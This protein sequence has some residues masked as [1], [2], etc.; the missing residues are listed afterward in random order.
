MWEAH[1]NASFHATTDDFSLFR[2]GSR[3]QHSARW[4]ARSK[5]PNVTTSLEAPPAAERTTT[6]ARFP[7][8]VTRC[9]QGRWRNP[10]NN[11]PRKRPVRRLPRRAASRNPTVTGRVPWLCARFAGTKSRPIS[12]FARYAR[13]RAR[14]T[15]P[16][17]ALPRL[18]TDVTFR[19]VFARA[20][21]LPEAGAR[22]RARVHPRHSLPVDGHFGPAGGHRVLP[23][24]FVRRHKPL[25]HPRQARDDYAEGH[26]SCA[27]N[28]RRENGRRASARSLIIYASL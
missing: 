15:P 9:S 19:R 13:E 5:P 28:T 2:D 20:G 18:F 27:K 10:G 7:T 14:E 11:W 12:C 26:T 24:Q 16:N 23:R 25:R 1:E 4:R 8:M 6:L 22:D 21:T 3:K 17:R